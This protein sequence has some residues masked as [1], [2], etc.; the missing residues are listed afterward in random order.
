MTDT[1]YIFSPALDV[2]RY[3]HTN[4]EKSNPE[5]AHQTYIF[6]TFFYQRLVSKPLYAF[7]ALT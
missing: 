6:N 5:V 7:V 3:I 2:F 4:L 1:S